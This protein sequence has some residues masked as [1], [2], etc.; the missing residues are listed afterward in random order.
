MR[1]ENDKILRTHF[2]N[3]RGYEAMGSVWNYLDVTPLGRQEDWEDSPEGY[4]KT[5]RYKWWRWHDAYG[6][7]DAK[8][9]STIDNAMVTL[10]L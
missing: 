2:I 6:S 8:L 10:K 4:P 5:S 3:N 9:A 7:E 1:A